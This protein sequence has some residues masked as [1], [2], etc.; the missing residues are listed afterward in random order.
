MLRDEDVVK[1]RRD[2]DDGVRGPVLLKYIR[3]LLEAWER[4]E[5]RLE[6]WARRRR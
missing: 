4:C 2:V 6:G 3:L 5:C 1:I